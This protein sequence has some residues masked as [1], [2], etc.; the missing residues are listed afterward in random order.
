M[1]PELA[2]L[3]RNVWPKDTPNLTETSLASVDDDEARRLVNEVE[4]VKEE[5]ERYL[6]DD[7]VPHISLSP[8]RVGVVETVRF[9]MS[10]H[11]MNTDCLLMVSGVLSGNGGIVELVQRRYTIGSVDELGRYI[12]RPTIDLSGSA[13]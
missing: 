6:V 7:V 8:T 5:F 10:G 4:R 3:L 11:S 12:E 1:G 2:W 13:D 9:F